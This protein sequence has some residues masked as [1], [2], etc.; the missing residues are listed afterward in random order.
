MT[1]QAK[2]TI[3]LNMIKLLTILLTTIILLASSFTA[4]AKQPQDENST[5]IPEKNGDYADPEHPGVRVRVFVHNPKDSK[6]P[7]PTTVPVLVCPVSDPDST[8]LVP[9][10]PWHLPPTWTYTLNLSSVPSSVGSGNL[11]TI[12]S[13]AFSQWM[14]AAPGKVSISQTTF[15]TTVNRARFDGQNIIAWGRTSGTALAVTY[16]WYYT[17]TGL[18]AEED[19]IFN[20]QFPW[21]WNLANNTCTDSNSYDAQDILTHETGHWMGLDDTYDAA[22]VNN[23]MYGY[24]SKGEVKKDTLTTG[25]INGVKAIYP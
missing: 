23:T 11:A 8:A 6:P 1:R 22:Y 17:S 9:A 14:S 10:T 21:Y 16:T 13:N 15:N 19:T 4:A 18:A 12:A 24:G 5:A 20:K 7:A 3:I 2:N 25:D